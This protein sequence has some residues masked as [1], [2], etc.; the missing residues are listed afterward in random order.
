M[1][2]AWV[3]PVRMCNRRDAIP[4]IWCVSQ[5]CPDCVSACVEYNYLQ[6]Y[7]SLI[8]SLWFLDLILLYNNQLQWTC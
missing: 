6:Y 3:L 4:P 7:M 5:I 8:A 2:D 1:E